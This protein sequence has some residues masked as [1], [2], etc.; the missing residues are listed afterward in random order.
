[1][2]GKRD[3]EEEQ[4]GGEQDERREAQRVERDDAQGEVDRRRDLPVGDRKQGR[5]VEDPLQTWQLS[6]HGLSLTTRAEQ[7]EAS[8]AQSDEQNPHQV[9]ERGAPAGG[10]HDE[11]RE[12][13]ADED[14]SEDRDRGA[15]KR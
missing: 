12:P 1:R 2:V 10:G 6:G 4:T 15:V 3:N 13:E 7:I 9:A 11:K 5:S 8:D 14:H